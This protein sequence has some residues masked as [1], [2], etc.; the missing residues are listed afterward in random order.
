MGLY[1]GYVW[2]MYGLYMREN[3]Q[4]ILRLTSRFPIFQWPTFELTMS[5]SVASQNFACALAQGMVKRTKK[6]VHSQ[7]FRSF[8][9][10][11]IF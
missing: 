10:Y 3:L 11:L 8:E 5:A 2:V 7:K 9:W 6:K 1:M 4:S